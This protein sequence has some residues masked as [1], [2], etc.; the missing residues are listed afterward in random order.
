[1]TTRREFLADTGTAAALIA[2]PACSTV[3]ALAAVDLRAEHTVDLLGTE[4]ARPRLSWRIEA[5]DR[6]VRQTRYRVRAG[7]AEGQNGLVDTGDVAAAA[8]DD[9][10]CDG[11]P[12]T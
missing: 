5:R 12:V 7:S 6:G 9:T 4:V 1:M 10:A 3:P 11:K 8:R 2:V